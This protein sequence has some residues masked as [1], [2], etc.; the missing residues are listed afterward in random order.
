MI[1]ERRCAARRAERASRQMKHRYL[2]DFV[3]MR[4]R[5]V[6]SDLSQPS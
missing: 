5:R 1:V 4:M 2:S 6:I 3:I